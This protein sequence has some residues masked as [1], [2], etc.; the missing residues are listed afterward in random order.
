RDKYQ[1]KLI[2]YWV[3]IRTTGVEERKFAERLEEG[4]SAEGD[5]PDD[6]EMGGM[7]EPLA[8]EDDDAS[9]SD[10]DDAE[11]D[12]DGDD[13]PKRRAKRG[14]ATG[15]GREHALEAAENLG[16][17]IGNALKADE[18]R[19]DHLSK[20]NLLH[21]EL[22]DLKAHIDGS[23]APKKRRAASGPAAKAVARAV[24]KGAI[25]NRYFDS[26]VSEKEACA[27]GS[28]FWL[29][30]SGLEGASSTP[31]AAFLQEASRLCRTRHENS[32]TNVFTDFGL[33]APVP[34]SYK[35]IGLDYLQPVLSVKDFITCL[36]NEGKLD[37]LFMGHG[38]AEYEQ[39]WLRYQKLNPN[40]PIYKTHQHRL[41][42]CLPLFLH[43][44]EGTSVKRR[45]LMVIQY[46]CILG[47]GSS[48]S[49]G[50]MNYI[51][52]SI[53]TRYLYSCILANEYGG[54]R[55]NKPLLELTRHMAEEFRDLFFTGVEIMWGSVEPETLFP[56][57]I[58]LKGDWGGLSKIGTLNRS[59]TRDTPTK[60]HGSWFKGA[61]TTVLSLWLEEKYAMLLPT[62]PDEL[63][64][65]FVEVYRTIRSSNEFLKGLYRSDTWLTEAE[66]R[67]AIESGRC[68][69]NSF[70]FCAE[71]AFLRL[72]LTRW[73]Y[74]PKYHLFA[75]MIFKLEKNRHEGCSSLNPLAEATQVDEDF[76]GR[77]SRFSVQVSVRTIA[78]RTIKKYLL[79]L[80]S[81]W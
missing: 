46:Q 47:R 43:C 66:R 58:G 9:A 40:H 55:Q 65:Y 79:S 38:P 22:A 13:K 78:E 12:E 10:E 16:D 74:Q 23:I 62:C 30:F 77:I 49:K 3:D 28:A 52:P 8:H 25:G 73:K 61:D 59:Y 20:I 64:P 57:V 34:I 2:Y 31:S 53:K 36:S 56:V 76:V 45:G 29:E 6:F 15:F 44:D 75:E 32:L 67:H 19:Q 72:N 51:E 71:H 21:D 80:A 50:D 33:Q 18:N 24:A 5:A 39:F 60:P 17:V 37:I 63:K 69:L 11:D 35:A 7:D 54:S 68:F 70:K 14:N 26:F 1:K 4:I 48:H 27:I 42:Q 41:A 81:A